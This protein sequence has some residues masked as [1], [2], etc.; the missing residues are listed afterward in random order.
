[1]MPEWPPVAMTFHSFHLM[2]GL[3]FFFIAVTLLACWLWW[4]GTLF[5]TR[6]LL[7]VFVF[8]IPLPYLANQLG[9]AT[10]EVGRQ[11][12]V[13]YG[14]MRTTDG[15][16][17]VVSASQTLSSIL[18]FGLIYALLF[19]VFLYVLND[20]IQHGPDPIKPG[21]AGGG[22]G[23]AA[24]TGLRAGTGGGSLTRPEDAST[25]NDSQSSN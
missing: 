24:V 15:V 12:W 10:A 22:G 5:Q 17:K 13:V 23:L 25:A 4:R 11:P 21:G 16:S 2:V 18:M 20:K 1:M 7:W 19:A 9:W 8:S 3:G 14:L 6:W